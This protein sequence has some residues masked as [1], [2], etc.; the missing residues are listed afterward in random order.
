MIRAEEPERVDPWIELGRRVDQLP[1]R[2]ARGEL[3]REFGR[4]RATAFPGHRGPTAPRVWDDHR[5]EATPGEVVGMFMTAAHGVF[6]TTQMRRPVGFALT[7][8]CGSPIIHPSRGVPC[9]FTAPFAECE[10]NGCL[11]NAEP[12]TKVKVYCSNKCK[13]RIRRARDRANRRAAGGVT[14][15]V[16][17]L[18]DPIAEMLIHDQE[19]T[20][21][22]HRSLMRHIDD[23]DDY[24]D[25]FEYIPPLG[26]NKGPR[27]ICSKCERSKGLQYFSP[28]ADA[29][30]GLHPWCKQCRNAVSRK[31]QNGRKPQVG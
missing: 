3:E 6:V 1:A 15:V 17:E 19:G 12:A 30:D 22:R 26:D 8:F 20:I 21:G 5:E 24:G 27:K 31:P 16:D 13:Q 28:K 10:C 29:K 18:A 4:R 25:T 2:L 11:L 7:C 9:E 23:E 14:R